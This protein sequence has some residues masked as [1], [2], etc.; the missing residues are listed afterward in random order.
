MEGDE[1]QGSRWRR[2]LVRVGI[3]SLNSSAA[4][5]GPIVPVRHLGDRTICV[6]RKSAIRRPVESFATSASQTWVWRP[7]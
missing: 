6:H 7:I 1:L 4:G 5:Q 3:E 2:V